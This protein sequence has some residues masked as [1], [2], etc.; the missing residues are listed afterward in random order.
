[1][2]IWFLSRYLQLSNNPAHGFGVGMVVEAG[3]L[4]AEGK[5]KVLQKC[6]Q[7]RGG[8]SA[9][10]L[11]VKKHRG[12][13]KLAPRDPDGWSASEGLKAVHLD[14]WVGEIGRRSRAVDVDKDRRQ[15]NAHVAGRRGDDLVVMATVDAGKVVGFQRDH[16]RGAEVIFHLQCR[17]VV[18]RTRAVA[19][20]GGGDGLESSIDLHADHLAGH[21]GRPDGRR[22]GGRVEVAAV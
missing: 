8:G 1:M 16:V 18:A 6:L 17:H 3:C 21:R 19:V 14:S 7:G 22:R 9:N 15:K 2:V 13:R 11:N 20:A 10:R 12:T 5:D 4:C